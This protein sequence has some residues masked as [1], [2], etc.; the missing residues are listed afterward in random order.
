M[1]GND[2]VGETGFPRAPGSLKL[3]G[4]VTAYAWRLGHCSATMAVIGGTLAVACAPRRPPDVAPAAPGLRFELLGDASPSDTGP[5]TLRL[6][7]GT[8]TIRG[9][10]VRAEE[11][12][13]YGD[14]DVTEPHTLRLT[15]YDSLPGRPVQDPPPPTR[16]RQV[17]YR[18]EVGPLAPG[19]YDVW[20]GRFD[21]RRQVVEVVYE[22]LHIE[23]EPVSAADSARAA[24][25]AR[26]AAD[27]LGGE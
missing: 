6:G 25:A 7:P 13:L 3:R 14:L 12:G 2:G 24:A 5:P 23:V 8:I 21:A 17:V 19:P 26:E 15:L 9:M 16:Y 4:A 27:T 11:G 1:P 20:V 18:A 10:A 22:P